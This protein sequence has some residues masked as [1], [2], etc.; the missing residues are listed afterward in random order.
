MKTGIVEQ[1]IEDYFAAHGISQ[2]TLKR[3]SKS[4]AHLK[5]Y[6]AHPEPSTPAQILGTV[7]DTAVFEPD[8][9]LGRYHVRPSSYDSGKEGMKPWHNGAKFCKDWNAERRDKTII[10]QADM[11]S[12]LLMRDEIAKHPAAAKILATGQSALSLYCEDAD[13]G[14]QQKARPDWLSG[15]VI[16]DLKGCVDASPEGFARAVA[17]FGYAIQAAWY[18]DISSVLGLNKEHFL[19]ICSES[20]PPYAVAV[21]ELDEESINIGRSQY[22][23]LLNRYLECVVTDQ[24]PGYSK[25]VQYLSLP[26]WSKRNEMNAALLEDSPAQPALEVVT[27]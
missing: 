20:D 18:L 8:A 23:R 11:T 7:L 4:P 6:V 26:N 14:L 22:R 19:F 1:P 16:A 15:N 13:T 12:V 17:N 24:W 3:I 2:S 25:D 21:Y 5:Y 27:A 10:P 9:L